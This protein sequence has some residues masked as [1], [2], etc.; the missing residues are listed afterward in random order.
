MKETDEIEGDPVDSDSSPVCPCCLEV[1]E[2]DQVLFCPKCGAPIDPVAGMLPFE[3]ILAQGYV[4]RRAG[5]SPQSWIVVAGISL[6]MLPGL[7]LSVA[8]L[9]GGQAAWTGGFDV[10]SWP[11]TVFI[12][13]S[14]VLSFFLIAKVT[15][16]FLKRANGE[17]SSE[18]I[19]A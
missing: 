18:T 9:F 8:I 13:I 17:A 6:L 1:V 15:R 10:I 4:F 16:R 3:Q 14:G 2:S 19:E 7:I 11:E 12:L 5:D